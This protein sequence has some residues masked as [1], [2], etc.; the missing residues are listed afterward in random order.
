MALVELTSDLTSLKYR[1]DR[2]GGGWSGQPFYRQNPP[3]RLGSSFTSNDFLIR[4]GIRT[5]TSVLEDEIRLTNWLTNLRS[6]NGYLFLIKQ[7]LLSQQNPLTGAAPDRIYLPTNTLAQA[8]VNPI[9]MHFVKQG[10]Q[11]QLDDNDK[12]EAKTKKEYNKNRLGTYNTNKLLLLFETKLLKQPTTGYPQALPE[13]APANFFDAAKNNITNFVNSIINAARSPESLLALENNMGVFGI[14]QDK[15]LLF[16]YQGGPNAPLGG[17][18]KVRRFE[19]TTIGMFNNANKTADAN[20]FLVFT[21]DLLSKIG[22]TESL[23]TNIANNGSTDFGDAGISNFALALTNPDDTGVSEERRK[24]LI[25][26]PTD[27]KE[28]N[29]AKTYG[30]G[31]PGKKG[32]DR[33]VY[34][35]TNLKDGITNTEADNIY[36]YDKVNAQPLYSTADESAKKGEGFDEIIKF[37]IGVLDLDSTGETR[38]TTWIHLKAFDLT[39]SDN[40][41][42]TW[43]PVKYMGRGNSFYKYDGFVRDV[44]LGFKIAV[45]SKYEQAFVYDK[46]NFLASVTAPNYSPGG[47][48]RGN[49]V[50]ITV[51]DYLNNQL[52][53]LNAINYNISMDTPWDI[54]KK[55][56]GSEDDNSLQLP[57]IV[58]VGGFKITPLHNFIDRNVPNDYVTTGKAKPDQRYISLG[59]GG[60]GYTFTQS[61]RKAAN[62]TNVETDS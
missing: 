20:K 34:Y 52:G 6:P 53:I 43:N 29:R 31:N 60:R 40:Y 22:S 2:R 36:Q 41:Q 3:N 21:H 42:S 10:M 26:E 35:T 8:A 30:E 62:N 33:S 46:L 32:R 50:K 44:T 13:E 56:D 58:E 28:F 12:Y 5:V 39:V 15:T 14:S 37:N 61:Q 57:M 48:M 7:Q 38:N 54:G 59:N 47:F 55:L 9:G 16:D 27:Y 1:G 45:F 19:D 51:G 49:L 11:L 17:K 23:I 18:T 4:G 25:G 24:Q